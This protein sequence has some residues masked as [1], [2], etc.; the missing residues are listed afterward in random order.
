MNDKVNILGVYYDN[1]TRVEL[2]NIVADRLQTREKFSVSLSNPEFIIN[3]RKDGI[4][5]DYLNNYV[6]FNVADGIGVIHASK[7]LGVPLKERVTGTDFI[8]DICRVAHEQNFKVFFFGG[9]PGTAERAKKFFQTKYQNLNIVGTQHGYNV[10]DN[11]IIKSVNESEADIVI[12]CLGCPAQEYWILKN[13]NKINSIFTFGNGGAF[14]YYANNVQRA[15]IYFR[16]LGLEWLFR[17]Y[18]DPSKARFERQAKTLP[19]FILLTLS[20]FFNKLLKLK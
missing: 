7:L 8:D 19:L 10:C 18:Q 13:R 14:D 9:K 5:K 15:P 3:S 2:T 6:D 17:L 1:L 11:T 20:S 4:L 12:V 16:K